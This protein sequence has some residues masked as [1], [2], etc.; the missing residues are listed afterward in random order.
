MSIK[1]A[2]K[3]LNDGDKVDTFSHWFWVIPVIL[4]AAGLSVSQIDLYSP[5][6]D[7]FNSMVHAGFV[8]NGPYSPAQIIASIRSYS[9]AHTPGYFLALSLWG[10][11]TNY[12]VAIA[13]SLTVFAALLSLTITYRLARDF[14][15][16]TAGLIAVVIVA[17]NAFYNYYFAHV[18]MYPMIVLT[19]GIILWLY[20]RI[21]YHCRQ[22]KGIDY[23]ALF[24]AVFVLC[25]LHFFN[26]IFVLVLGLYHLFF[27][28]KRRPWLR[29][30]LSV[31][32]AVLLFAPYV[33]SSLNALDQTIDRKLN[34]AADLQETIHSWLMITS[35]NAP[36][37]FVPSLAG[38]AIGFYRRKNIAQPWLVMMVFSLIALALLAH[39]TSLISEFTMRYHLASWLPIVLLLSAGLYEL[40]HVRK[41][42]LSL[43]LLWIVAGA[44]FQ[45][46][47]YWWPL[48]NL[49]ALTFQYP[50]TQVI[51]RL[52]LEAY[53]RPA[54][55]VSTRD[56]FYKSFLT[57]PG[58]NRLWSRS[59]LTP[60]KYY[61]EQRGIK[62]GV[63]DDPNEPASR[64]AVN[65][66]SFWV[67]YQ[68]PDITPEQRS[69]IDSLMQALDYE[70]C[71]ELRA[72]KYSVIVKYY[73]RTLDCHS[74]VLLQS[75]QTESVNY[76]FY[77]AELN[78]TNSRLI[79]NDQWTGRL[80]EGLEKYNMSYQL[81]SEDRNNVAQLDLPLVH[82]NELRQFSIDVAAV[83]PGSYRLVAIVYDQQTGD[84]QPWLKNTGWVPHMMQ[85]ANIDVQ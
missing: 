30:S 50:P 79:F 43:A 5:S 82:E 2:V 17:S 48:L 13:R 19:A 21:M 42:L 63:I 65:S 67:Y 27:A 29:I 71:E 24:V 85:L 62:F 77:G 53:P 70:A 38:L 74:P 10:N 14:V 16:P 81:I 73:W 4:V 11:L 64:F 7:E 1:R 41:W 18:R 8:G 25:N 72:G 35:N 37:L 61:F 66:P 39:F 23:L 56:F 20:F 26:G 54:V 47:A 9:P 51:S 36:L 52:A 3:P 58:Y 57:S 83:T 31:V 33:F 55:L 69:E 22:P 45:T 46:T 32:F 28:P 15:A 34:D 60:A 80:S 49:R 68:A 59:G 75:Y 84:V 76:H 40:F 78:P 12:D 44:Y 6:R